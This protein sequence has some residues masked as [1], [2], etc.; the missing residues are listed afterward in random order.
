VEPF[1]WVQIPASA[2]PQNLQ[3]REYQLNLFLC[4]NFQRVIQAKRLYRLLKGLSCHEHDTSLLERNIDISLFH[5]RRIVIEVMREVN[6]F[7]VVHGRFS[8]E[9][10]DDKHGLLP[11]PI[12]FQRPVDSWRT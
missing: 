3:R 4:C 12:N 6:V 10:R 2:L 1:A 5:L 7:V 8:R 11:T 9:L